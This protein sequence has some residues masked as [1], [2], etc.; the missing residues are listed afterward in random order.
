[1][2]TSG[3]QQAIINVGL[4][5]DASVS[6]AASK[7]S[8]VGNC[9]KSFRAHEFSFDPGDL[10]R[11]ILNFGAPSFAEV[12]I[13]GPTYAD[14]LSDAERVQQQLAKSGALRDVQ[15]EEPLRYPTVN[16]KIDRIL[17][18]QFGATA[19][20]RWI[21][22]RIRHCL[23]PIRRPQLLARSQVRRELPGA[24]T[25][26]STAD[27]LDRRRPKPYQSPAPPAHNPC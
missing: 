24:G 19:K 17:A 7:K 8:S 12:A 3:P 10:I 15:F 21:G 20:R 4:K 5:P 9:H 1:M 13:P 26:S 18:G 25:G 14:V 27:D 6:L 16:V 2:W 22:Y 23:Q 11:Q